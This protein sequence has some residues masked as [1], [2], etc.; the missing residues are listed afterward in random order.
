MKGDEERDFI[1]ETLELLMEIT[2]YLKITS[3]WK[4]QDWVDKLKEKTDKLY[5]DYDQ[6]DV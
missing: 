4:S 1:K 6:K 3:N 5:W 2:E